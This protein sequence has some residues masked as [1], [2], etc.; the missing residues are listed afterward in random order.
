MK[1]SREGL[2]YSKKNESPD[3]GI[4]IGNYK[5]VLKRLSDSQELKLFGFSHQDGS[6]GLINKITAG[7]LRRQ[8]SAEEAEPRY[9]HIT[10]ADGSEYVWDDDD[11]YSIQKITPE[12][13]TS[14]DKKE[15]QA[16]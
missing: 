1:N 4:N 6:G 7:D 12:M 10:F 14:D 15:S 9:H 13:K 16:G 8:L 2:N 5:D 11:N 3:I